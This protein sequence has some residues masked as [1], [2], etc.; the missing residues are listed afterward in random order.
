MDIRIIRKGRNGRLILF[1]IFISIYSSYIN[2]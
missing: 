1:E 2:A